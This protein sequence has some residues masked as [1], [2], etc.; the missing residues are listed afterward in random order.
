MRKR[1]QLGVKHHKVA[2]P[3]SGQAWITPR[4]E[5]QIILPGK[6]SEETLAGSD[7]FVLSNC[8]TR[9]PDSSSDVYF[10]EACLS[11]MRENSL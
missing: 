6:V 2:A 8:P 11:L 10:E 9:T 5:N 3:V 7:L 1:Y 4:L